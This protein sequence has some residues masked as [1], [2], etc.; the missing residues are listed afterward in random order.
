MISTRLTKKQ[1]QFLSFLF[2]YQT[3]KSIHRQQINYK[4]KTKLFIV[5]LLYSYLVCWTLKY[6]LVVVVVVVVHHHQ[7]LNNLND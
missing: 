4:E 3:Q 6:N 7:F 1:K 5:A 2:L